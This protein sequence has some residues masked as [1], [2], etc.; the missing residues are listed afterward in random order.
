MPRRKTPAAGKISKSTEFLS[1]AAHTSFLGLTGHESLEYGLYTVLA[2]AE[3][4]ITKAV[5]LYTFL[6]M[7]S[8]QIL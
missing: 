2:V 5:P 7:F 6:K 8:M 4:D 1:A 3:S